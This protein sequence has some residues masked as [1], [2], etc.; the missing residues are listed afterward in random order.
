VVVLP[1][2]HPAGERF[3]LSFAYQGNVITDVG[4]GVLKVGERGSWYPNRSLFPR[5]NYDLTFQFPERLTLV[6]TGDRVE[7]T[8]SAGWKHSRWVSRVEIPVAGFNLGVY[9]SRTLRV[10]GTSLEVYAT[11]EA[12]AA[13]E[14]R[15]A[16]TQSAGEFVLRPTQEGSIPI[17]VIPKAIKPL[18]PAAL[19]D[20]VAEVSSDAVQHFEA[21]FGPFPYPRLA[22]SQAPGHFGQGWPSLVYL[23]TLSFLPRAAWSEMGLGGKTEDFA[24]DLAVAHEI[25]HQWWGNSVGWL[26]YHDQWISEGF[27]SYA[28]ALHLARGK[29]G[30]RKF[31]DLMRS[32]KQALLTQTEKDETI[33]SGGPIWLG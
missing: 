4:N 27:A 10:G 9:D 32:Y 19:L 2:A 17:Q 18:V 23:P 7:E 29:D 5:A 24:N 12:E 20:R 28:A 3:R 8:V 25:A 22:I 13:L 15:H 1:T 33:E 31:R 11:R 21:L 26:T 16:A 14:S 6:A 30:D